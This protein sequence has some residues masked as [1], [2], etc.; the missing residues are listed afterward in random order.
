MSTSATP[1][2]I[3][4]RALHDPQEMD[5]AV[6]LQKHIWGFEDIDLL[7]ARLFVVATK[8]GGQAFGAYDGSRMVGYCLAIPGLKP[9]GL[10]Y[11][12]SHMLG[13]LSE[14]RD[15]GVGRTLKLAQ[16]DD[17]IAGA[18][19]DGGDGQGRH[20]RPA[21]KLEQGQLCQG[22]IAD[23]PG[24]DQPVALGR[25]DRQP[26]LGPLPRGRDHVGGG[27]NEVGGDDE[28]RSRSVKHAAFGGFQDHHDPDDAPLGIVDARLRRRGRC[29]QHQQRSRQAS[30]NPG[31]Q[32]TPTQGHTAP[33]K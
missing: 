5:E 13:V 20:L 7:P 14:Y 9:G 4:V 23:D 15:K 26:V 29:K 8:I 1:S 21:S 30:E 19:F 32:A 31:N 17:A 33:A 6:A 27:D 16:R 28:A 12:H 10:Y 3:T 22:R 11:L 18:R 2:G 25:Y 24:R